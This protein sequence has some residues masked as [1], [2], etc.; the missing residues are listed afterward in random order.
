MLEQEVLTKYQ[1]I[2][3][4][5]LSLRTPSSHGV[6]QSTLLTYSQLVFYSGIS[7]RSAFSGSVDRC[8]HQVLH[9]WGSTAA[10]VPRHVQSHNPPPLQLCIQPTSRQPKVITR[11]TFD[12]KCVAPC[13]CNLDKHPLYLAQ[14]ILQRHPHKS[15]Q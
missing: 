12:V 9:L 8:L 3:R 7:A 1:M 13:T 4:L 11:E 5:R 2:R 14:D 6:I 15:H 10:A